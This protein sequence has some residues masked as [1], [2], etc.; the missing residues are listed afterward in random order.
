MCET[1]FYINSVDGVKIAVYDYNCGGTETVLL[2]HGWPL[3]HK[4]Y[5]YQ[6]PMLIENGYRVVAL[7]LRGFGQSDAPGCGYSY[8]QM[9][10]DILQVVKR[11][12][13]WAFTLVGFSMG[14]AISLRYMRICRGYGVKKL[15]LLSAA[16]PCWTQRPGYPY[17]LTKEYVDGLICQ[18][19]TDRAQFAENFSHQLFASPHS[20]S[21]IDWFGQIA[22]S[23][24]AVGTIG[25][26]LS[27]RDED[28]RDDFV[29]VNVPTVIIH[30]DKDEVVSDELARIQHECIC[31]SQL[32]TLKD[33]G[34]GIMYDQLEEFNEIFLNAVMC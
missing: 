16:A 33:S 18:I 20:A 28:G 11:M 14:G 8:D 17:G 5:E 1:M 19:E 4:I 15:I 7:D 24:S 27:L 10:M 30:G 21:I 31:G 34:H 6:I 12:R 25:A 22:L 2:I 23:A 13:L 9:A 26:A 32:Y 3:S 29:Y